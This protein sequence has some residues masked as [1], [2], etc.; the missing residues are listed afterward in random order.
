MEGGVMRILVIQGPNLNLL[1]VRE[2]EHYGRQ[3]L[4]ELHAAIADHARA[5]GAQAIFFQSNHEGALVDR[6]QAAAFGEP[7]ERADAIIINAA[8]YTHTSIALLDA[9]SAAGLPA[10]EVHLSDIHARE[11]FRHH[12]MI[13][14]ACR[15]QISGRGLQGYLE[16]VDALVELA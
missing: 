9:L 16:A 1:G 4:D 2:P 10:I 13:A 8:A 5:R 14:A 6:I 12:S 3:T 11:P 7:R 15:R